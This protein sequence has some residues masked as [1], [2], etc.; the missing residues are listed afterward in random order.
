MA[1]TSHAE[2]LVVG[3]PVYVR[4]RRRHDRRRAR[5]HAGRRSPRSGG[6][7]TQDR[8]VAHC[9]GGRGR[10]C[11]RSSSPSTPRCAPCVTLRR[12]HRD[13]DRARSLRPRT[14]RRE[15]AR[16][17]CLALPEDRCDRPDSAGRVTTARAAAAARPGY[18]AC[19]SR[20]ERRGMRARP[21]E[22]RSRPREARRR[23]RSPTDGSHPP[24]ST[25]AASNRKRDACEPRLLQRSGRG[26]LFQELLELLLDG[27]AR[28]ELERAPI[29]GAS[30]R[31]RG[32]AE[33]LFS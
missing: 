28:L 15:R 24:L 5:R 25:P 3:R 14:R 12:G 2:L 10:R 8:R 30:P 20:R 7:S 4:Q 21:Q 31:A 33:L 17:R 19:G 16:A 29:V 6:R 27:A 13:R 1:A 22:S 26:V 23:D 9:C 18:L 32:S 11:V